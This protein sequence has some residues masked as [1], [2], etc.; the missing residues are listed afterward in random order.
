MAESNS[1]EQDMT[2]ELCEKVELQGLSV[3]WQAMA[4]PASLN[5]PVCEGVGGRERCRHIFGGA[6]SSA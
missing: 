4:L 6:C 3:F 1:C 2:S 5:A